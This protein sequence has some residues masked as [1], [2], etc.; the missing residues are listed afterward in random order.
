M[1]E[2]M[3]CS[4]HLREIQPFQLFYEPQ[5][6]AT[7]CSKMGGNIFVM[8]SAEAIEEAFSTFTSHQKALFQ[9]LTYLITGI[10]VNNDGQLEN[11]ANGDIIL[12]DTFKTLTY[13]GEKTYSDKCIY[14]N[15]ARKHYFAYPVIHGP[16]ICDMPSEPPQFFL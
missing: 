15:H 11:I 10:C 14:Y 8:D 6:V 5:D 13:D 9:N 3:F 2:H 7:F 1:E 12:A 16:T 4:W